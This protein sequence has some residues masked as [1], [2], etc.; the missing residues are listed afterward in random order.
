MSCHREGLMGV[1]RMRKICQLLRKG[2]EHS[3]LLANLLKSIATTPSAGG[4]I[5]GQ[6]IE[7]SKSEKRELAHRVHIYFEQVNRMHAEQTGTAAIGGN[8][9]STGGSGG[10]LSANGSVSGSGGGNIAI[11][12]DTSIERMSSTVKAVFAVPATSKYDLFLMYSLEVVYAKTCLEI[13]HDV[14]IPKLAKYPGMLRDLAESE[15]RILEGHMKVL[16]QQQ[17]QKEREEKERE[18]REE[19]ERQRA[20]Q[21]QQQQQHQLQQQQQLQH[22]HQQQQQNQQHGY[23]H[24]HQQHG[25]HGYGHHHQQQH[26]QHHQQQQYHQHHRGNVGTLGEGSMRDS[27]RHRRVT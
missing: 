27:H 20:E 10:V 19:K 16:R 17:K 7:Q 11:G 3:E 6:Q 12:T 25:Q 8:N 2:Q 26:Q 24:Q 13:L 9:S 21:Q 23:G 1:I 5:V 4:G 18:K 14:L 22:G 15:T